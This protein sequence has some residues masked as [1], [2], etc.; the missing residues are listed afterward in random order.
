MKYVV[1]YLY[2]DYYNV[3]HIN[4]NGNLRN[5]KSYLSNR[6]QVQKE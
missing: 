4:W 2:T 1:L 3:W 5:I 6:D